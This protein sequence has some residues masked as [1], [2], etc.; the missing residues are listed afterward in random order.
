M[1]RNKKQPTKIAI[2]LACTVAIGAPL[3]VVNQAVAQTPAPAEPEK[4]EKVI[5][6]GSNLP[7]AETVGVAPVQAVSSESIT[8]AGSTDV[9][10]ALKALSPTF[11]GNGNVGQTLNNG[12]FGESYI[13]LRNLP[14]LVLV[15]GKR[16]NISPFSTY[17]GTYAVDVNSFPVAMIERI[18]VLKDGAS[19]IYGSD[20]IGGVV[21]IITKK[22]FNGAEIDGRYGFATGEGV[23]NE[24]RASAVWGYA[25]G[26]T[27][28][29]AGGSWYQ[30]DPLYTSDRKT[31][32]MSSTELAAAGLNA[33]SYYSGS[34][35]GRVASYILA[36]S[37]LAKGAP[38]YI[39]GLNAPPVVAIPAGGFTTVP[40]YNAAAAAAGYTVNGKT[41][42]QDP[43]I[44]ISTTPAYTQLHSPAI[45]NTTELGTITIQEQKR[46]SVFA[47][48]EQDILEDHLTGYA[49]FMFSHNEGRAR[50]APAPIPYLGPYNLYVPANSP[51]NPFGIA[52][53]YNPAT[54]E[55]GANSPQVRSR[56]IETGNREFSTSSDFWHFVGGLKGNVLDNKYH[57]DINAAYSQ[58]TSEQVQNSATAVLLNQAMAP[59]T[60][61]LS[62]LGTP[63]YNIFALPGY[64]DPAAV[65][66]IR[67]SD[68]QGGFSDLL[69]IEG[70]FR[71][72][73]FNLPAGAF[74]VAIGAQ[75][76]HEKLDTTAG[77]ILAAGNLI[78]LNQINPFAGGTR[79]REAGFIEAQIPVVNQDMN[80]PAVYKFELGA[81]GR[82]ETISSGGNSDD[83]LVP[84]V[85]FRWQPLDEQITLRGTYSQGFNVPPMTQLYGPTVVSNPY[86]VTPTS[87]TDLTAIAS[88]QT[89]NYL[90]NRDIPP[91]TAETYTIGTV[92]SP[93]AL[94]NLTLSVDYYHI[95]Q[96]QVAF[97]AAPSQIIADLNA[98]GTASRYYN[99]PNLH[100]EPIYR[101]Q[102]NNPHV[103]TAGVPS[104]Y[105]TYENF[106]TLNLPLLPDCSQRTEGIDFGANYKL[107]MENAGTFNFFANVNLTLG[108]DIKLGA[109]SRWMSY[110]GQYTDAQAV[111]AAQGM[112]PD[113][114]V[115]CGLTWNYRNFDYTVVAHYLPGVTDYGDMHP[116]VGAPVNDFTANGQAWK[117]SD[118]YRIDMQL[119]Y[120]FKSPSGKKWYDGT[121]IAIGCNN[122][123]DTEPP[124][125]AS[126]SEDN[127]DKSSY[128]ILGRFLY[129]ELSKKF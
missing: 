82:Y 91:S 114:N 7:T 46:W 53:G 86:V 64:N 97:Y 121:R 71:G 9:L 105:I 94:K 96:P 11:S 128:D 70:I 49:Q 85:G 28:V 16:V 18:E 117:V 52:L 78:G 2:P 19:T 63:I 76:I 99:N 13:A 77:P 73:I 38:G 67:A 59:G 75:Y 89:V 34:F 31:G 25:K 36:G 108:W 41:Y 5:V 127:T 102:S 23:Y 123:T 125:I 83:S 120:N 113:Y 48:A 55:E 92:L 1:K 101:D 60:G 74:Q 45:L 126:S 8:Q 10:A 112:I 65:N 103:P 39:E 21:N 111:G 12:G 90:S 116:S 47:N 27:R 84:K 57:Y 37:P 6:T 44:P 88:Q 104:T 14:T 106:G 22:D 129:V 61:G 32:S 29:N 110:D 122:V 66:A 30:S 118:Y 95:E 40:A 33:P 62:Q 69:A 42:H 124:L 54:E 51:V 24:Y 93:K 115:T 4:M 98:K 56:L 72:E 81:S 3:A 26:G 68:K 43:Y 80:I 100:G 35:P 58:T 50:L 20:A 17:V 79:E 87:G 107:E 109:G 15:D 119:A